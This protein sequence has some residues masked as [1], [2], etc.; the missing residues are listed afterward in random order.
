MFVAGLHRSGTSLLHRA[1]R[2]HPKISGFQGTGVP[3]DEGQHLQ[4]VFP[5]ARAFGGPGRFAFDARSHMDENHPLA[6]AGNARKLW[7]DWRRYWDTTA[8]YFVEKSPPNIVRTRF[9]QAMFPNSVFVIVLRHPIAVSYALRKW[10]PDSVDSLIEHWLVSYE[11]FLADLPCLQRSFVLRYEQFVADP[12]GV[13]DQILQFI[14]LESAPHGEQVDGSINQK[15][16]ELW[17]SDYPDASQQPGLAPR[18]AEQ[19]RTRRLGYDLARLEKH[20]PVDFLG[21]C[22][23]REIETE[24]HTCPSALKTFQQRKRHNAAELTDGAIASFNPRE[25]RLAVRS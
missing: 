13:L 16:F 24:R 25:L 21:P 18:S 22:D 1:L 5:P 11:R 3:E 2:N 9:L 20:L 8:S 12:Q 6:T 15:Y 4:S 7:I 17:R 23:R 10:C 14:G 19:R